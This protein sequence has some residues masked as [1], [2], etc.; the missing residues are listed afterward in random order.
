M[1]KQVKKQPGDTRGAWRKRVGMGGVCLIRECKRKA[2]LSSDFCTRHC[3][4]YQAGFK[5]GKRAACAAVR[6]YAQKHPLRS[7]T[8]LV[9]QAVDGIAGVHVDRC[10]ECSEPQ[11][12][13]TNTNTGKTFQGCSAFPECRWSL[14]QTK[15]DYDAWLD[16]YY[17]RHPRE[18]RT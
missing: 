12:T 8:A 15:A 10:P 6:K 5:A 3:P 14:Q 7:A 18:T 11:V 16:D 2:H 13:R 1:P 17:R 9:Y 4:M